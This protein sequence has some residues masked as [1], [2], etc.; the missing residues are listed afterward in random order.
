MGEPFRPARR[1]QPQPDAL[2][3]DARLMS[4]AR[5]LQ[6]AGSHG[7]RLGIDDTGC[8]WLDCAG[9]GNGIEQLTDGLRPYVVR[10]GQLLSNTLRH[11][12]MSHGLSLSGG[13]NG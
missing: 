9:C 1:E 12:V 8:A 3:F 2:G 7:V 6:L 10:P 11:L 4:P 13:E 5:L